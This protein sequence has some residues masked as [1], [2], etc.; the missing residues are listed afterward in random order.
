MG[1]VFI[2]AAYLGAKQS[3]VSKA[4]PQDI[5]CQVLSESGYG[6]NAHVRMTDFYL[7]TSA[8]VY[9]EKIQWTKAWVPA[10]P[11]GGALHTA[12]EK[13]KRGKK[14]GPLLRGADIRIIVLLPDARSEKDVMKAAE[15]KYIQGLLITPISLFNRETRKLM[16][17]E[18][19]GLN[20]DRC[21]ILVEGRKPVTQSRT[22]MTYAGGGLLLAVGGVT[23]YRQRRAAGS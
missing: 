22:A 4:E 5:S 11:R 16:Q 23:F 13:E 15:Q 9:E 14:R 1:A 8:Y 18:Y 7:C 21:L 19:P 10:V 17:E 2:W 12:L 6:D 20:Y 3:A